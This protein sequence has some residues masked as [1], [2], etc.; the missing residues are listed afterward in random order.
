[1]KK[2]TTNDESITFHS[3]EYDETY[4]STSGA[5]EEAFKK[6]VEPSK[7]TEFSKQH[8]TIRI[9]DVC[10]GIGYNSAAAIDT[11]QKANPDCIIEIIG[12]ENDEKIIKQIEHLN[13]PFKCYDIIK[14]ISHTH[15]IVGKVNIQLIIKDARESIKLINTK[16][17]FVF[18]DPFSPKKCPELWTEPFLKD[19]ANH[20]EKGGVLTTYSC[21][22]QVR[23]NL[24]NAGFEVKDGPSV[25]RKA[26]S[27]IA[28]KK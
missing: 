4:H 6:F 25:G 17:D 14:E 24:K 5:V 1:M 11:I 8:R 18:L 21:A 16:F 19:I 7:I 12:L 3:D 2:I 15:R 26:P 10:F 28:I 13:P 22:R 23:E 27:T 9:L 20:M